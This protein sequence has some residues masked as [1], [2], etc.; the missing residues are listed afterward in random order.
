MRNCGPGQPG[1]RAAKFRI[2]SVRRF[3][4]HI[5]QKDRAK[6]DFEKN[7]KYDFLRIFGRLFRFFFAFFASPNFHGNFRSRPWYF[8]PPHSKC[9]KFRF[10]FV[11]L[12]TSQPVFV[13]TLDDFF[14]FC[15]TLISHKYSET[16][17]IFGPQLFKNA[18]NLNRVLRFSTIPNLLLMTAWSHFPLLDASW[19]STNIPKRPL[20]L[21]PSH[22]KYQFY[23]LFGYIFPHFQPTF[24]DALIAI[25][26]S[27]CIMAIYKYS[28]TPFIFGP[29]GHLKYQ[30]YRLFCLHFHSLSTCFWWNSDRNF[31]LLMHHGHLQIFRNSLYFWPL[32]I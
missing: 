8:D 20:F 5:Y 17:F 7:K 28:E 31:L 2:Q 30:F 15:Y 22:L 11:F 24:D 18:Y 3:V 10:F 27:W 26:S 13:D 23:R 6:W 1:R 25:S 14:S 19:S 29:I 12:C 4:K 21:A 9:Q 16:P 32:A